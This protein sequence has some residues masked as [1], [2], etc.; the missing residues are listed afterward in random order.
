VVVLDSLHA[1]QLL[2]ALIQ[3]MVAETAVTV[4]RVTFLL[5][6]AA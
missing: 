3:V 1:V 4:D 6:L 2:A 5:P